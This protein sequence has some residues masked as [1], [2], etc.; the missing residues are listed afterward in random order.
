MYIKPVDGKGK[1]SL[2]GSWKY[3]IEGPLK[4]MRKAP[5]GPDNPKSPSLLYNAM[6]NPII[7][8][9][10]KG[11]IWYQGESNAGRAYQYRTLLP[12]MITDWRKNWKQGDFPFL[13]VQLA[14]YKK[15][16]VQPGESAWAELREAQTMTA[17]KLPAC[18]IA[19]AIDIGEANNIHPK[20]KQEVGRRLALSAEKIAYG[21]NIVDSGPVYASMKKDGDRIIISFK[22][23]GSG[24]E[25]VNGKLKR[26]A[27]A[28]KDKKF[29]WADAM[30]E[31]TDVIVS[32]PKVK[33]P[34]AVRY[35][36]SDNPEGCNLYNK[37]GLPALPFRTDN[38]KGV[39]YGRK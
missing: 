26:F 28:G 3:R 9:G 38:W 21:R 20:N 22:N 31:G 4:R 36:W 25:A 16:A 8:Y 23:T 37:E 17:Q 29:V 32:S 11:A 2:A 30:I 27:V 5:Y 35:A 10:I 6:I 18:G 24:L 7:P 39:T 15:A 34:V 33:A 13:I 12:V 1:I 19:V 14:N